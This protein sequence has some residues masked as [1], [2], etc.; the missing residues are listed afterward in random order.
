VDNSSSLTV[1]SPWPFA[2]ATSY[3]TALGIHGNA[4]AQEGIQVISIRAGLA[5][6][7][8]SGSS[9]AQMGQLLITSYFRSLVISPVESS[10]LVP[11]Q[12]WKNTQ[13]TYTEL[14]PNFV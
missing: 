10:E 11:G 1:G 12:F 6:A 14:F 4:L 3:G 13:R 8:L 7:F 2:N 9:A 5:F